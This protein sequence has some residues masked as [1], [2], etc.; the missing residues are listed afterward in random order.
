MCTNPAVSMPEADRVAAAIRGCDFVVV[1]DCMEWTDTTRLADVLLPAAT[2]GERDG[3]VT[4]S[5]RRISRQR[6]FRA[7]PGLARQDWRIIAD[8][9]ERDR[10]GAMP[11]RGATARRLCRIRRSVRGG[12]NAR[13]RLRHLRPRRHRPRRIRCAAS[14][15]LA[16]FR[17]AS[18]W[19][20]SGQGAFT[21][22]TA[23]AAWYRYRPPRPPRRTRTIPSASTRA[24][25]ATSG[26]P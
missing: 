4:N 19:A 1:S 7:P 26:T 6:P 11:L 23:R 8:V 18:G 12:G 25:S 21:R 17:D 22:P 10:L 24:A 13:Q 15:C 14:L 5:E 16:C 20:F 3:T 9:A 2:W